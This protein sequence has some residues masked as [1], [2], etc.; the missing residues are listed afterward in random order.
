[1]QEEG[2]K[3]EREM[4]KVEGGRRGVGNTGLDG[5]SRSYI[6]GEQSGKDRESRAAR[7]ESSEPSPLFSGLYQL[8]GN[9][10]HLGGKK[11]V[12]SPKQ[13]NSG[14]VG[15]RGSRLL[16]SGQATTVFVEPAEGFP[17]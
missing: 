15:Q 12:T 8:L 1:M 16:T 7:L 2:E 9:S 17:F 4:Q 3:R 6:S 11:L 13:W 10:A 14:N 5:A